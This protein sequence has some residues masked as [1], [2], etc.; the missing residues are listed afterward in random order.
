MQ[1]TKKQTKQQS[2]NIIRRC[3]RRRSVIIYVICNRSSV[4]IRKANNQCHYGTNN[5][6]SWVTVIFHMKCM[7]YWCN[8]FRIGWS[9]RGWMW[10]WINSIWAMSKGKCIRWP[11]EIGVLWFSFSHCPKNLRPDCAFIFSPLC[12][13]SFYYIRQLSTPRTFFIA[14]SEVM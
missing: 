2:H 1:L 6:N 9:V 4:G 10:G 14:V 3:C 11:I 13:S 7:V 8:V 12:L 5:W